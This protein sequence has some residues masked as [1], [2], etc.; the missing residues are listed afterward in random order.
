MFP[1]GKFAK[2]VLQNWGALAPDQK[3][4]LNPDLASEIS[5]LVLT[6]PTIITRTFPGFSRYIGSDTKMCQDLRTKSC[7][8]TCFLT[9]ENLPTNQTCVHDKR[10]YSC[11][12]N[13]L[14]PGMSELHNGV[15]WLQWYM[16]IIETFVETLNKDTIFIWMTVKTKK[17]LY[18]TNRFTWHFRKFMQSSFVNEVLAWN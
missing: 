8:F 13:N 2:V 16:F 1:G 14:V 7:G 3:V 5:Y 11:R 9:S 12:W 10:W 17:K 18:Q 6:K 15:N 4:D